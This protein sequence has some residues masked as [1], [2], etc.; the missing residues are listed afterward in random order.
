MSKWTHC[1]TSLKR[2]VHFSAPSG[3]RTGGLHMPRKPDTCSLGG[4]MLTPVLCMLRQRRGFQMQQTP[5][6]R[7]RSKAASSSRAASLARTCSRYKCWHPQLSS[8]R[9]SLKKGASSHRTHDLSPVVTPSLHKSWATS[10]SELRREQAPWAFV[11]SG[12]ARHQRSTATDCA[13]VPPYACL[14][15]LMPAGE[16]LR[17]STKYASGAI[18]SPAAFASCEF[19]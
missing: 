16:R 5:P 17:N 10:V 8:A 9:Q 14:C 15:I 19:W 2:Q 1:S 7:N 18:C 6:C 12:A 11:R 3:F 4:W 13:S